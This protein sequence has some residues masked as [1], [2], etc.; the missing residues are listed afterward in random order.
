VIF[1]NVLFPIFAVFII[2]YFIRKKFDIPINPLSQLAFLIF[3]PTLVFRSLYEVD[4]QG[5]LKNI[6][7]F[8]VYLT[9]ITIGLLVVLGKLRK[10]SPKMLNAIL[11]TTLFVNA[12]NYGGPFN[13]FA[14]GEEGFQLAIAH[15]VVQVIIMNTLGIYIANRDGS[16]LKESI[17]GVL[18]MP[19]VYAA[20]LGISFQALKLE[21]PMFLFRPIDLLS[22][23]TIPIVM[24]LLGMQIAQVKFAKKWGP[25][26]YGTILKLFITPLIA[27]IIV[28]YF[29][30]VDPF[31]GKILI[32]QSAMPPAILT[33][34]IATKYD[35]ESEV[36]SGITILSTILSII[37]LPVLLI[38]L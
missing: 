20:I 16:S 11:L 12:G 8:Q 33:T 26:S 34:L 37:T 2:G 14:F 1:I 5:D 7:I 31:L 9:I 25:I 19:I 3:L 29:M 22:D 32:I 13:L 36:V 24:I 30:N 38:L 10:D 6:I 23:A 17:I 35:C 18:K 27:F 28:N 15:W 4:I 21:L